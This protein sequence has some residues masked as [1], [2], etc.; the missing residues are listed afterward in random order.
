MKRFLVAT[1]S[2]SMILGLTTTA[3]AEET[4]PVLKVMF[5]TNSLTENLA[6]TEYIRNM[7]EEAGVVLEA[8]QISSGW[9]EIK[10]TLLA[11]GDIPDLIIGK[12]AIVSVTLH[13]LRFVCQI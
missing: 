8:E 5:Y 9:D 1:L 7:A 10:S 4:S 11:S 6:D 12:D 13:S 2:A 3:W